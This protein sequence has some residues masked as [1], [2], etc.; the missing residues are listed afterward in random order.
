MTE[1]SAVLRAVETVN[2]LT[3]WNDGMHGARKHFVTIYYYSYCSD[4]R[5]EHTNSME[6]K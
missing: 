4:E 1:L 2:A 6:M 3:Y 5:V